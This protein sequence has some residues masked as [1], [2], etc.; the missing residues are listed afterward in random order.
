VVSPGDEMGKAIDVTLRL[1]S[2]WDAKTAASL[3]APTVD[4]ERLRRQV[5]AASAWG[6]CKVGEAVAGD[7]NLDSAVRLICERGPL[8]VRLSLD[9]TT[10]RL[11][12]LNLVPARDQRCVP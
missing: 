4:V 3:A 6:T 7:G 8:L 1:M 10:R 5:A 9:P 2:E 12:N 11:T